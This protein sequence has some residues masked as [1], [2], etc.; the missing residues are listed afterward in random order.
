MSSRFH[1]AALVVVCTLLVSACGDARALRDAPEP[2]QRVLRVCSD[3]N[4]LP[5]SNRQAQGFENRIAAM[6]AQDMGAHVEYT[7]FA[8]R[9][10]F[11]RNTLASG[12]CDVIIGV[13][14]QFDLADTTRP[15]YRSTHVFVTREQEHPALTSIDDPVLKTLKIGV[16]VVGDDYSNPPPVHAL[17]RRNIINNVSGYS[18]YGDYS[19]PNPP[20]RLVEAVADGSVDVAILW[21]P[22][23]GY[24]AARQTMALRVT[25]LSQESDG[26]D[27]PFVF[28]ISMGVR[29]GEK[30]LLRELQSILDRRQSDI[31]RILR[32]YGVPLKPLL[33]QTSKDIDERGDLGRKVTTR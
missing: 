3:P 32:D 21:G 26:H 31:D 11:T 22:I 7:W 15:Y 10:G 17:G 14:Y 23:A 25:P 27:L 2:S 20:A 12:L 1:S 30:D 6:V 18:I 16:H 9:R 24:F 13:P 4:N 8:Q 5:F 28:A 19:Q 33:P 29:K